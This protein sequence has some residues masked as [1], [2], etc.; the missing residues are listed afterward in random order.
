MVQ[1]V[2]FHYL[3]KS[4][5][6]QSAAEYS[7]GGVGMQGQPSLLMQSWEQAALGWVYLPNS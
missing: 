7:A 3:G 5:D 4:W 6:G 2:I 1:S